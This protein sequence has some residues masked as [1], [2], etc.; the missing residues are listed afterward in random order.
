MLTRRRFSYSAPHRPRAAERKQASDAKL[1]P[2]PET[3]DLGTDKAMDKGPFDTVLVPICR[4]GWP[5]IAGFALGAVGLAMVAAPLG[6]LGAILTAWCA[7]FFRDPPRVTPTDPG[8]AVSPADGRVRAV[9]PASPPPEL[10]MGPAP[11]PRISIFM[12]AFDVH[13]NRMPMDGTVTKLAYRRGKFFNASLNKASEDNERH[14]VRLSTTDGKDIAV[15]QI[16]GLMARRIVCTLRLD[17]QVKAGERFGMIRF[18]SRLD[19]YLDESMVP[20]AIPGQRTI[21]GETVIARSLAPGENAEPPAGEV[22]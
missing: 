13:V 3:I 6:W 16:A 12:N 17:Q 14:A 20:L 22:R 15:V 8:L 2:P 18:G 5:F 4:A 21:A 10:A 1:A 9:G 7:Y 19:V 11:R